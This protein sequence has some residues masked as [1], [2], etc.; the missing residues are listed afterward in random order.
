MKKTFIK[1]LGTILAVIVFF[2][3]QY[4]V[5]QYYG[6]DPRIWFFVVFGISLLGFIAILIG[7]FSEIKRMEEYFKTHSFFDFIDD[8][9]EA[10]EKM[11]SMIKP[12]IERIVHSI[13]YMLLSIVALLT[14][15]T[16]IMYKL[17]FHDDFMARTTIY[18]IYLIMIACV[19][20][21]RILGAIVVE[22]SKRGKELAFAGMWAFIFLANFLELV[23]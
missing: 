13:P 5:R 9:S 19:F 14:S 18:I 10:T 3:A 23:V 17:F 11:L 1:I 8:M 21:D 16:G 7:F 4:H 12:A 20:L 6:I 15:F 2:V 22:K